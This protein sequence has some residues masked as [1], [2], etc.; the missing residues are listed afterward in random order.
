MCN[1]LIYLSHG[2]HLVVPL[3]IAGR[4]RIIWGYQVR[5]YKY[6]ERF[7]EM[8]S[9]WFGSEQ[10]EVAGNIFDSKILKVVY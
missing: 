10:K 2:Y 4:P 7:G 1:N 9:V 8:I 5:S 6:V 3:P